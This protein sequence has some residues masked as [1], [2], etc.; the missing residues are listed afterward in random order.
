[1]RIISRIMVNGRAAD[2][3]DSHV[4]P[5]LR[6]YTAIYPARHYVDEGRSRHGRRA[7]PRT[8]QLSSQTA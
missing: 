1:M 8:E 4:L 3:P 5:G 2:T 7:L 6:R